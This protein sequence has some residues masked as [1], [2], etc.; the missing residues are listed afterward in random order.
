MQPNQSAQANQQRGMLLCRST[1]AA[2]TGVGVFPAGQKQARMDLPALLVTV[3]A[4]PL[5]EGGQ[6][7]QLAAQLN[8]AITAGA[9]AVLLDGGDNAAALY[10]AAVKVKELLRER[11]ALLLLDRLDIAAAVG[12]EGVVLSPTGVP[13]VVARKMQQGPLLLGRLVASVD[14]AV[15]AAAEGANFVLLQDGADSLPTPSALS[16]ARSSQRSGNAIPVIAAASSSQA[17]ASL[18]QQVPALCGPADGFC[19]PLELLVPAAAAAVGGS[20]SGSAGADSSEVA[21]AVG[22]L[23]Q[24]LTEGHSPDVAAMES[25]SEADWDASSSSSVGVETVRVKV[26]GGSGSA[27]RRLLNASKET[28]IAEEKGLLRQVVTLLEQVAPQMDELPLLRDAI[29]NLDDV[30]L[31][32]VVGEFNSGKST[33]I[34]A[35]L[36][37]KFLADGIL[38]TT[39][40]ISVLKYADPQSPK[41]Q[42]ELTQQADGLFVRHLPAALLREMNI[43][44]TPGTNVILERQQRL[45]EEYVPRADLVLF[46]LSADRPLSESE[47]A[48]LKYIRQWRKKVVF[49]VNKVDM[50]ESQDEVDAV[51]QFVSSNASKLL[52]LDSPAVL[53]ISGRSALKAKLS[54]GSGQSGGVLDS[55][56]DDLL[57]GQP[58][59]QQS[60]FGEF[61]KFIYDFL[62]GSEAAAGGAGGSLR[63]G[64]GLRLKLQTPLFVADAL[65]EA[66]RGRLEAQT[67]AAKRELASL[68]SVRQ[69]L[70]RFKVEM[71]KDADAQRQVCKDMVA[72]AVSRNNKFVDKTLQLSNLPAL[73][74]YLFGGSS[75]SN[76]LGRWDGDVVAGTFDELAKQVNTHAGWLA[77]NC[78]NQADYYASYLQQHNLPG[79]QQ[80]TMQQQQQSSSNNGSGGNQAAPPATAASNSGGGT[81]SSSSSGA[82]VPAAASRQSLAAV[83]EFKVDAARAL[84]EA[85]IKDAFL[86][87]AGAAAGAQGIGLLATS[88][89]GNTLE[90][91]LA[92]AVAGMASYVAVL[93]LPLKRSDIKGKVSKVA[94]NFVEGV[95]A[96]MAEETEAAVDTTINQVLAAVEPLETAW[97]AELQRLQGNEARR[98]DLAEALTTMERRTANLQ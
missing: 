74:G 97:R 90:D 64:E 63:G 51:L 55:W 93:N 25:S 61:E 54:C 4:G 7:E 76:I 91:I 80:Q 42:P 84:L 39:N 26:P 88:L 66:A 18:S 40:E 70:A 23:L 31:V 34:N 79:G 11:A 45:T 53:P 14:A 50:L 52:Q 20:G 43:V 96:A 12:A 6:A 27:L 81:S 36:G 60:R 10:E 32:V 59:W 1:S 69:Q 86:G 94:T 21:V 71:V 24:A 68:E 56:E 83:G 72:E 8:D 78:N 73:S 95:A 87:T 29:T 5:L 98:S 2:A 89:M 92:L 19:L 44:D 49:V 82:I 58:A 38:P 3:Q 62:V 16:A 30:F 77:T 22:T 28:L 46:V 35:L 48:F 47:L 41:K 65:M 15:A 13:L 75:A 33:V 17:G 85:E 9:T 57:A 37:E 67:A